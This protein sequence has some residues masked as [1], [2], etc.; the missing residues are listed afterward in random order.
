MHSCHDWQLKVSSFWLIED[1]AK[2]L[3]VQ[4]HG[5]PVTVANTTYMG[6]NALHSDCGLGKLPVYQ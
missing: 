1:F 3:D 5:I 2:E 6:M 4:G